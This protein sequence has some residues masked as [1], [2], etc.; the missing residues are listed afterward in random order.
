M[1]VAGDVVR[2]P[3]TSNF[4][5]RG[6]VIDVDIQG[7]R[8]GS[9]DRRWDHI[10][11]EGTN[12]QYNIQQE[13]EEVVVVVVMLDVRYEAEGLAGSRWQRV[14]GSGLTSARNRMLHWATRPVQRETSE[15]DTIHA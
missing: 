10:Q 1:S 5:G 3:V 8:E 7:R 12:I 4:M 9:N 14:V 13:E 2:G 6:L 15:G 11:A